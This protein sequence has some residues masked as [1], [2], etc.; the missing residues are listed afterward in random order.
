[1]APEVVDE[2]LHLDGFIYLQS[3]A[4]IG[5]VYWDCRLVRGKQCTARAVTNDPTNGDPLVLFK[6]PKEAPHSH[7]PNREETAAAKITA[8]VKRKA[9]EHPKQPPAQLL[10][11]ELQ[12]T[13]SAVLSQ[14]PAQPALVRRIRRTRLKDLP[15]SPTKLNAL[16]DIPNT[17]Q[18]TL[19]GETFLLYDSRPPDDEREDESE[20]SEEEEG[21]SEEEEEPQRP[22]TI[23]FA[24]R[25]NIELLCDS[26]TW[27]LDSTFKTAPHLFAQVFTILGL[28][29]RTS[30]TE[31]FIPI[32]LVY[33]L[34]SGKQQE[35]HEEVLQAVVRAINQYG[36][37][38]CAPRKLMMDFEIGIIN[39]CAK[40][41]PTVPRACCFFHLGQI[42]YRRV[43]AD[44][45]QEQYN[46]PDDRTLKRYTHMLLSLAFVPVADVRGAFRDLRSVCPAELHD[47]FDDFNLFYIVGRPAQ[48]RR[49]AVQPRYPSHL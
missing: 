42:V 12:G 35:R 20:E 11:T 36:L 33:A 46:D 25:K 47:V 4:A 28:R 41:F 16:R 32:P 40:V 34:L 10:R 14:L 18:A 31:E 39:A 21:E 49:R 6:G 27:F 38:T 17:Y 23:V 48:G 19:L 13:S 24:T 9:A 29:K 26:P 15:A 8:S 2:K 3:R 7:P 44:G 43:Q 37:P 22:R 45:L 1:M 5:R 30:A